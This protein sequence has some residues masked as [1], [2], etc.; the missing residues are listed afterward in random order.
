M[1]LVAVTPR[2]F[3]QSPGRHRELLESTG[4]EVRYPTQER[5]LRAPEL[6]ELLA[7]CEGVILGV[8]DASAEVLLGSALRVVVRFGIGVDNVDLAAARQQGIHVSRTLGATTTSVAELTIGLMLASAR[9]I[10]QMDRAVRGGSWSRPTG[11]ELAGR[12][13]GLVG[14]GRIG[15][16]VAGRAFA[17]GMDVI[18]HDPLAAGGDIPLVGFDELIARADVVSIHAPLTASTR[19]LFDAAVLARMRPSSILVNTARGGIIDEVAL[20][21]ALVEGPLYAAALDSFEEEPLRDSPLLGLPNVILT[22]H[23]GASTVEG[24]ERAGVIAVE[25]LC[26][27]LAGEPLLYDVEADL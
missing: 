6:R 3:R 2:G 20:A 1:T 19:H 13:L 23:S 25:E 5:P 8:D 10:P 4:F 7:G 22:P 12:T 14:T 17:L 16:Q 24:V 27:G 9:G 11:L 21:A 18:G 15:R 26:R